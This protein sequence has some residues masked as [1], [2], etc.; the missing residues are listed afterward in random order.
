MYLHRGPVF[1]K[2]SKQKMVSKSST[3]AELITLSEVLIYLY[4]PSIMRSPGLIECV[5]ENCTSLV[6]SLCFRIFLYLLSAL[7]LKKVFVC[8]KHIHCLPLTC[9]C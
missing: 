4:I 8:H 3:E 2:C 7:Q 1:V 5:V 9:L 6:V